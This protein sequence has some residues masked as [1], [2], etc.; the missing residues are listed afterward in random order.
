MTK[1]S[2]R[3]P[4]EYKQLHT[5]PAKPAL[6]NLLNKFWLWGSLLFIVMLTVY[7]PALNGAPLWD[8]DHHMT[9]PELSSLN[10]LGR[11]WTELGATQQYYPLVHSVFWL[12]Y[13]LWGGSTVG[14]HLLNILLHVLSSVLLFRILQ[15]LKIPGALLASLIFAI[16]PLQVETV[17]W[18]TELK[19]TLS[20]VFFLSAALVYLKFDGERTKKLYIIAICLFILGLM[21][22]SVIA[23]LP[24]SLLAIIWWKRG[25]ID[26]K[27]DLVPLLPF[28]MIGIV[29]GLFTAWVEHKFIIGNESSQFTSTIIERCLIAGRATWFYLSKIFLPVDLI[30]IYP[31]WNIDQAVW[32]Q[33]LFPAAT[34]LIAAIFWLVRKRSRAPLAIF[35]CFTG[36]LFPA[37]GFF[38]VYSFQFSYV[39]D[40]FQYLS[41][42]GPIVMASAL[43]N[44]VTEKKRKLR[45][46]LSGILLLTLG[47][48]TWKQS[49]TYADPETLYRSTIQKNPQCWM[50]Y[51][52]LGI[53]LSKKGLTDEAIADYRKALQLKP[54]Y[55]IGINNLGT[56]LAKTGQIR[57][58]VEHYQK[59]LLINPKN[60]QIYY[61]LGILFLKMG[62][63]NDAIADFQKALEIDPKYIDAHN[64]LGI[65]LAESGRMDEGIEQFQLAFK[66]NPNKINTLINLGSAFARKGQL[67]DAISL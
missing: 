42:I 30:F 24:V 45:I 44:Q 56:L 47:L 17:A 34:L 46:A 19:N 4:I 32:W 67:T 22:K 53:V 58:A 55:D 65:V 10:G 15:F 21:S 37:L 8:D 12:E 28:F 9:R 59:A 57:E 64:N 43:M 63:T 23:T 40:H 2:I 49:T 48:L 6:F 50:A 7:Y 61:S 31:H 35:V 33:Y 1:R 13:R 5:Q 62:Q 25:E 20:G 14:Y 36:T 38:N 54:D 26:W 60:A 51:N 41:C 16:H 29:Y 66:I 11:I 3:K 52:N 18:I 27:K 39:A